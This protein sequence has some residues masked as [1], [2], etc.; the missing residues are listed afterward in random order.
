MNKLLKALGALALL[1]ATAVVGAQTPTTL[2]V[3]VFPGAV[4][5]P[6]FV[7]M[8]E[9]IFA[10]HGIQVSLQ[11]TPDS[12]TVRNGLA[13]GQYD[14]A[15]A[16]ADNAI[17]MIETAGQDA[18]IVMGGD[19]GLVQIMARKD[20]RTF[21]DLRGKVLAVDAPNTA[22]ALVAKKILKLNGLLEG[23]DYTVRPAGGTLQR[24]QA[25]VANPEL[26]VGMLNAP[27]SIT[28]RDQGLKSLGE[29]R[30][31]IGPY[32]ATSAFVMR[33]WAEAHADA[34]ER[35]IAAYIESVRIA[36]SPAH[37]Q[38]TLDMLVARFKLDAA[39]AKETLD[40]LMTPGFGL[41]P[42]ARL[43]LDGL[44]T[45]LALRA[46]IQGQWAGQPPAPDKFVDLRYYDRALLRLGTR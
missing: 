15:H 42:D 1:I 19:Y 4:N 39:V 11:N 6:L 38:A 8:E 20:I 17:A 31:F 43:D 16:T 26:A 3:I 22:Y 40:Q 46:E 9:G 28:V 35:Y 21:A 41:A 23:R 7:G 13:A 44:R 2:R 30:S 27:F 24:A 34:L 29:A 14:I 36:M 45:V 25:M 12:D 5:I 32:Q 18:R 33:P 37:K 10:K